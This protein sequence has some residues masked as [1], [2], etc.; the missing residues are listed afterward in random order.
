M[1]QGDELSELRTSSLGTTAATAALLDLEAYRLNRDAATAQAA[2]ASKMCPIR[3]ADRDLEAAAELFSKT[4][5]EL[6][7]SLSDE[8]QAKGRFPK[9][10]RGGGAA[11]RGGTELHRG[12]S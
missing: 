5:D 4:R 8:V 1:T 12:D 3:E 11:K 7:Q 6:K 2:R 9:L 10:F